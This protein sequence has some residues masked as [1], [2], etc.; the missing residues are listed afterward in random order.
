MTLSFLPLVIIHVNLHSRIREGSLN[1]F[2]WA[3]SECL[4]SDTH[5]TEPMSCAYFYAFNGYWGF[6]NRGADY[7]PLSY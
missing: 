4:L 2:F 7:S 5:H 3:N 6:I 1:A